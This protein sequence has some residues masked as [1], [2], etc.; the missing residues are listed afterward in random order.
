MINDI[1]ENKK[2]NAYQKVITRDLL[3]VKRRMDYQGMFFNFNRL[4]KFER[5]KKFINPFFNILKEKE[6]HPKNF[7]QKKKGIFEFN[8]YH[9]IENVELVHFQLHNCTKF[10]TNS[11]L[12]YLSKKGIFNYNFNSLK[13]KKI[14]SLTNPNS[15]NYS[16]THNL[17]AGDHNK[18]RCY[19]YDLKK[20]EIIYDEKVF[21]KNNDNCYLNFA[22]FDEEDI[23]LG[24]NENYLKI[25]NLNNL[26]NPNTEKTTKTKKTENPQKT[27]K[28]AIKS[29][30][31]KTNSFV[32][33]I[34]I[35]KKTGLIACAQDHTE[36]E[37]LDKR[38]KTTKFFLK[39]HK[40]FNFAVKFLKNHKIATGGQDITTR[41]WDLRKFDKEIFLLDGFKTAICGF[42]FLEEKNF[43]F[44]LE[45]F[46]YV[47]CYDL[48]GGV[49][50]RKGFEFFSNVSGVS[51][52]PGGH[53][54][55]VGLSK[56]HSV[57]L[58]GIAVFDVF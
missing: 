32:N 20:K 28:T 47:Y 33:H 52:G 49:V 34:D 8:S 17:I 44:V 14:I 25:I 18:S 13:K 43:L 36:I 48:S 46:G 24:G 42:E 37:L 41:I 15:L 35:N 51:L 30:K 1:N 40:D 10:V 12:L 23:I 29:Q 19:I 26:Q 31:I 54:L 7:I 4:E 45:Y 6:K 3:L 39:G 5:L 55:G 21:E 50:E 22:C 56:I 57:D 11:D 58:S 27:P 16:K 2:K 9:E 53:K 38:A